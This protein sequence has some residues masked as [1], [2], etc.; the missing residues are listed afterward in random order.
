MKPSPSKAQQVLE[1]AAENWMTKDVDKTGL[2]LAISKALGFLRGY[3]LPPEVLAR[4]H[5]TFCGVSGVKLWRGWG[6]AQEAWCCKC[7]TE[8]AGLPDDAD[9]NG[10]VP[11]EYP[12][13]I[14]GRSDQIYSPKKGQNLLPWVPCPDGE[15]WGYMSVPPE[16]CEWWR[17]LPTRREAT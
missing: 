9:E 15:T 10:R 4:Y 14:D 6:S 1:T 2:S 17:T 11:T 8:Q 16:G 7:G 3:E 12:S 13:H 5:C